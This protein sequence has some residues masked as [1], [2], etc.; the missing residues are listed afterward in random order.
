[1]SIES[2]T[3]Q[4]I[5][6]SCS[7]NSQPQG[8]M[9]GYLDGTIVLSGMPMNAS[10][11]EVIVYR[12][13][14]VY[15]D[16][17]T[18]L[19]INMLGLEGGR[20]YVSSR[21]SRFAG[22]TQID[23]I[24]GKRPDGS[25]STG[26]LQQTHA[27]P[28]LGR[29]ASKINQYV[30]NTPPVRENADEAVLKDITRDGQSVND[31]MREVSDLV[32]ACG[33]CWIGV[34]APAVKD[35][36]SPYTQAEKEAKKIRPYWQV[37]SP[38]DV[39]DWSFDEQGALE[40]IKTRRVHYDDSQ[41]MTKPVA[42]NVVTLWEKGLATE[43]WIIESKDRR[44]ANGVRVK[45]KKNVIP[46][47]DASGRPMTVVPFVLAGEIANKPMAFDDLESINRTIMDLGSVDRAN[48]FN[49]NY[50]QLVLPASLLQRAVQDGY[51]KNI[52]EVGKLILG[53]KYPIMLEKDDPTPTYLMPST[54]NLDSG[55]NR[56]SSLKRE[57][58]EV[59]GLALEQESRQVASAEAKAWDFL[60]VASVMSARAE[61]LQDTEA[62]ALALTEAWDASFTA[63]E[64][65][66]NRDFDVGNFSEEISALIMAGNMPMPAEL[67]RELLKKLMDRLD[68]IGS[69]SSADEKQII[70][71]AIAGFDP[72]AAFAGL[73]MPPPQVEQ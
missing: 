62:K 5:L 34:D 45:I 3:A 35:D 22:E 64:P 10:P 65:K 4:S 13:K 60:D 56:V 72:D 28:Y 16:R 15:R 21:L 68:R 49:S 53:F 61:L 29:I 42:Q 27:F 24:G 40:W 20:P 54:A 69:S 38:L 1:M 2:D 51:A 12:E 17:K 8:S 66:Y 41:P 31:L 9:R 11:D 44:Y 39:M 73:A 58:F 43:Y 7:L 26:R 33:W 19:Q 6:R 30:F 57:L 59:V 46:L 55:S 63:W 32:F 14:P 70:L 47:T 25:V 23:W 50:P 18:Q 37:Y 48:F 36:G 52:S 67:S 71:D